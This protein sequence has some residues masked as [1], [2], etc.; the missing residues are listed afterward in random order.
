[1]NE[2]KELER[3]PIVTKCFTKD[4]V[5][6]IQL[7]RRLTDDLDFSLPFRVVID[8]DPEQERT[9]KK[10]YAPKEAYERYIRRAEGEEWG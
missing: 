8:Y 10:V 3:E 7:F 4:F 5:R 6:M 1:M 9:T 2:T